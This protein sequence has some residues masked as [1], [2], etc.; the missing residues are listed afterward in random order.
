MIDILPS[1]SATG[2]RIDV[3]ILIFSD[4]GLDNICFSEEGDGLFTTGIERLFAMFGQ[5]AEY[6]PTAQAEQ[7]IKAVS[8][9]HKCFSK[10]FTVCR[11]FP[12]MSRR[13]MHCRSPLSPSEWN[14]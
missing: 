9:C 13:Q 1:G 4:P 14:V 10:A 2:S 3:S 5:D 11:L 8:K 12:R 6:M 7:L